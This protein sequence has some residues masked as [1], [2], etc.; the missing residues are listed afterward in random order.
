MTELNE[1]KL[2]ILKAIVKDYID[3]A[4]AVGSRTLSKKYE[5]GISAATIR[6]EMADLEEMGYLIQPHTSSGRI[7]SEKGYKL[8]VDSLMKEYELNTVEKHL[9]EESINKNMNYMNDLIHET[10]KLISKLTNYTTIAV[11]KNVSNL[12]NIKHIQLVGLDEKSIVLIIVTE[13]GEIKNTTISTNT[14]IDQAKL[15]LISDKLTRKLAG[16]NICEIDEEFLNY[17]KYEIAENSLIIDKLVESLNFGIEKNET[18]ISLSGAT[19][20]FNFP[21]FSDVVRAKTF[22]TMLEEKDNISN[23]LKSKGIQKENLNIIIGSDNQCEVAQDC[24][25]ITATYNIDKDVVGKI[26]LIGPTR[27]DYAKVYSILNYMGLLLNKK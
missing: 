23:M 12:Q 11:T 26:S 7:P 5:L 3:T 17:I 27:M 21:E 9:I 25:I 19:N 1:R 2:N 24:S 4:E 18:S 20:I 14:Y 15:N 10:S 8:Y 16:K 22:L 13:K 6:N